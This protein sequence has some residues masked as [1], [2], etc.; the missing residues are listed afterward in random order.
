MTEFKS[1]KQSRSGSTVTPIR[2]RGQKFFIDTGLTLKESSYKKDYSNKGFDPNVITKQLESIILGGKFKE[3]TTYKNS[4]DH[5]CRF[6]TQPTEPIL[7]KEHKIFVGIK[8]AEQ[9]RYQ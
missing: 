6:K 5:M 4:Y 1:D 8:K 9:S 7:Q 2:P 3:D